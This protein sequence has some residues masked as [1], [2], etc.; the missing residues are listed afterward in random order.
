MLHWL[1]SCHCPILSVLYSSKKWV[2]NL[3]LQLAHTD[4]WMS[5]NWPTETLISS[6]AVAEHPT[7]SHIL[8]SNDNIG[9]DIGSNHLLSSSRFAWRRGLTFFIKRITFHYFPVWQ[10]LRY[11]L[12]FSTKTYFWKCR[13]ALNQFGPL[14]SVAMKCQLRYILSFLIILWIVWFKSF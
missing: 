12:S 3:G 1:L 9:S 8:I 10:V 4:R 6:V 7:A 11:F 2:T 5:P 13:R 14:F